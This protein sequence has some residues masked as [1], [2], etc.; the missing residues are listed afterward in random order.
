MALAVKAN[1]LSRILPLLRPVRSRLRGSNPIRARRCLTKRWSEIGISAA[2]CSIVC[3]TD[4]IRL[5]ILADGRWNKLN[6][7]AS[8]AV[9]T[10][11]KLYSWESIDTPS[12]NGAGS[13]QLNLKEGTRGITAHPRV[14]PGGQSFYSVQSWAGC[15]GNYVNSTALGQPGRSTRSSPTRRLSQ[16]R[17]QPF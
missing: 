9:G 1:V 17:S 8:G 4:E 16:R 3:S 6:D 11:S 15:T 10:G 14:S 5:R 7:H 13:Y 2:T 12:A